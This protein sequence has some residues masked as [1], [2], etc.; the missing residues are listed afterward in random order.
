MPASVRLS[1]CEI[2][3][4]RGVAP[5]PVADR[6]MTNLV[7]AAEQQAGEKTIVRPRIPVPVF[8]YRMTLEG[9]AATNN[10]VADYLASLKAS[11]ALT[12]VEL[13]FI[14][15]AGALG[16]PMRQFQITAVLSSSGD[17]EAL[18][19][20][21]KRLMHERGQAPPARGPY[22]L[23]RRGRKGGPAMKFTPRSLAITLFVVGM[24]VVCY[25]V[26]FRPQNAAIAAARSEVEHKAAMLTKLK[27][28]T[29]RNTDLAKTNEQLASTVRSIEARL[30]SGKELDALV[31]QVS[32]LAVKAGLQPPTMKML[33]PLQAAEYLEQPIELVIEGGFKGFF[34]FLSQVE[35]LPRIVRIHDMK[36]TDVQREDAE[37][38]AEFTLSIYFQDGARIATGE[39]TGV[40]P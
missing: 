38:K 18:A 37:I 25:M 26:V 21:L 27:D 20:S 1:S 16:E 40:A 17:T 23:G 5:D 3:S 35:K 10:D 12:G 4:E 24:P 31:K 36:I 11:P 19:A 8:T 32:N 9:K 30:P 22:R 15:D 34:T 6:A 13:T 28:E 14:R 2:K 29:V 39:T 7:A 33:P